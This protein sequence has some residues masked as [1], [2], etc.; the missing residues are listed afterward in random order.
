VR[1]QA[2]LQLARTPETAGPMRDLFLRAMSA[3]VSFAT[4]MFWFFF[5]GFTFS[6]FAMLGGMLM[7]WIINRRRKKGIQV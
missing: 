5:Y 1:Q 2:E 6:L 3:E 7:V 4:E